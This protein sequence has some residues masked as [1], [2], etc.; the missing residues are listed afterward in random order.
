MM[1]Q[2]INP[3]TG[4]DL[5]YVPLGGGGERRALPRRARPRDALRLCARGPLVAYV[6]RAGDCLFYAHGSYLMEVSTALEAT[7]RLGTARRVVSGAAERL[8]LDMGYDV[9]PDGRG[10]VAVREVKEEKAAVP[11][12][13]LVESWFAEFRGAGGR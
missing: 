6:A 10:F 3:D 7:P 12:V 2:V 8:R 9:A 5:Y 11:T 13:T 1:F 4:G